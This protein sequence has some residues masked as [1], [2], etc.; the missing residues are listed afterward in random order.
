MPV[1][2]SRESQFLKM[3]RNLQRFS[4]LGPEME[5]FRVRFQ[6]HHSETTNVLKIIPF[7]VLIQKEYP[8]KRN[9]LIMYIMGTAH[10]DGREVPEYPVD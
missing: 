4:G 3:L 1:T 8:A 5:F 9:D 7:P 2:L 6:T 10:S